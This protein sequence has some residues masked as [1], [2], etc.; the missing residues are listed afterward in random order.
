MAR[1]AVSLPRRAHAPS[2]SAPAFTLIELLVVIAIISVLMAILLPALGLARR[3][4]RATVGAANLRSLSQLMFIYCNNNADA[5]L[6]PF[7][8]SW[9][10]DASGDPVWTD[11][12]S[13]RDP[14]V[15]W[16]FSTIKPE[17]NTEFFAYYWYSYLATSEGGAPIRDEQFSPADPN[18]RGLKSDLAANQETREG[19]M[20]WPC[21][22]LYSP[23][24][25]LRP[26]RYHAGARDA[27]TPAT[28][29]TTSSA[30]ISSPSAKVLLWERADYRQ[31]SRIEVTQ[32]QANRANLAPAWNNIRAK[33]WVAL[34]DGSCTE[35]SMSDLTIAAGNDSNL[36]P[37]GSY[38]AVDGPTLVPPKDKKDL[39]PI[40]GDMTADGDYPLYF[41]ATNQGVTGRDIHH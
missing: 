34:A 25:W 2:R 17:W 3:Q 37:G 33:P 27:V 41:W 12:V 23:T 1:N 40:G 21:S 28:L 32:N 15:V 38:S 14:A 5:F 16:D 6:N 30:S 8:A 7:R 4:A 10:D 26:D 24:F 9:P 31:G 29:H 19:W 11:V 36:N 39:F 22:F 18:I 13:A 35:V 20:L